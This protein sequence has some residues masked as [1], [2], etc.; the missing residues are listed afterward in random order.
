MATDMTVA[1]T[2]LE[3]LGGRR[4][5]VMTGASNFTGDTN[6]L[7][8][9]L[10][11]KPGFVSNG[12]NHVEIRLDPSDTYTVT[13]RRISF[14]RNVKDPVKVVSEETDIYAENLSEVFR[15]HTGLVTSLGTMGR[16]R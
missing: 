14:R 6:K 12:I 2:I 11:G 3:Q 15:L 9:A 13:F 8:F 5:Q 1:T 10:P 4:F 16:A 7:T